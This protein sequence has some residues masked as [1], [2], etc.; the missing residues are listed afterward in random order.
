LLLQWRQ[1]GRGSKKRPKL[2]P[3]LQTEEN[4]RVAAEIL[5]AAASESARIKLE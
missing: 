5:K 1:S 4:A 2:R 3:N